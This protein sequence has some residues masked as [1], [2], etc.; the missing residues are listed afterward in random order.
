VEVDQ[1]A[2]GPTTV[3][4][5][6]EGTE[7]GVAGRAEATVELLGT[8]A[9]S[10]EADELPSWFGAYPFT[11][12]QIGLKLTTEISGLPVLLRQVR[13][14]ADEHGLPLHV[15]GSAAGVLYAAMPDTTD[16]DVASRV[17]EQLRDAASGYGGSVVVL[18]A[19]AQVRA[20]V[21]MWGP[22]PGLDLM[23]RLKDQLDPEHRLAPGRFVGG[24]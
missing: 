6:L 19:P 18:T 10:A 3:T 11:P 15:R 20:R 22:V 23:R 9:G 1:P 21:D 16:P 24:I 2:D 4:V 7:Q 5:V 12:G 13:R 14:A 17:V 8:D